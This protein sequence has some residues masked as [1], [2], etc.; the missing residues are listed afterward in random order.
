MLLCF[1]LGPCKR[2]GQHTGSLKPELEAER[3]SGRMPWALQGHPLGTPRDAPTF[4]GPG[5]ARRTSYSKDV[6]LTKQGSSAPNPLGTAQG[7]TTPSKKNV[8]PAGTKWGRRGNGSQGQRWGKPGAERE[9]GGLWE[10]RKGPVLLCPPLSEV[11]SWITV[12]GHPLPSSLRNENSWDNIAKL[13]L[14]SPAESIVT[15]A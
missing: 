1:C 2:K 6:L 13:N 7:L 14:E 4:T 8:N 12:R 11:F 15:T 9:G 5:P 3:P 10:P